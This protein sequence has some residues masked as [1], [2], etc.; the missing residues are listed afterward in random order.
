M[1]FPLQLH[2]QSVLS[3]MLATFSGFGV[4]MIGTSILNELLSW[5]RR[6]LAWL[7]QRHNSRDAAAEPN[8]DPTPTNEVYVQQPQN[9]ES[10]GGAAEA[11]QPDHRED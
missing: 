4:T 3:V 9:Q 1:Y 2:V 10:R 8:H 11:R 7:A 5:R 6:R